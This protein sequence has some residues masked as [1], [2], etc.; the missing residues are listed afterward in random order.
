MD[1]LASTEILAVASGRVLLHDGPDVVPTRP[2]S[3]VKPFTLLALIEAGL[4]PARRLPCLRKLTIAG[5]RFDCTHPPIHTVDARE[6]LA[7]S[8]NFYFASAASRLG[9]DRLV[10]TFAD[11][12]L[13]LRIG[14]DPRLSAL[15]EEGIAV[16]PHTLA[17]AYRLLAV[18]RNPV[19]HD[20]LSLA[21]TGGTGKLAG[22]NF[23]GKTGTAASPNRVS[24]QAWFA[25]WTPRTSPEHVIVVFL[26]TGRGASDAA[27][28]AKRLYET[29]RSRTL[30]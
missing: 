3:T 12:G 7:Y 30:R 21:T 28:A 20:G 23:A 1:T 19:V 14:T 6:A 15:G 29:W 9:P 17:R 22:P 5:R 25:G 26:P 16:T 10:Q 11:H 8:C 2:G 27:P 18:G 24:L 4:D 13:T